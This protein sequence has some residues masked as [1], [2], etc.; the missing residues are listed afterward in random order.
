MAE[1]S[2]VDRPVLSK[3]SINIYSE[4]ELQK[5]SACTKITLTQNEGTGRISGLLYFKT[6]LKAG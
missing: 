4:V 3:H 6:F 2:G 5:E 1:L